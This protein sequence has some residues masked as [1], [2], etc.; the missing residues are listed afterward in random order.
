MPQ[1]RNAIIQT[2]IKHIA[3]DGVYFRIEH[4]AQSAGVTEA[5]L[6]HYFPEQQL[7][8]DCVY[9]AIKEEVADYVMPAVE[10][11][12][13]V[14]SMLEEGWNRYFDWGCEHESQITA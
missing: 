12:H 3:T 2:T 14:F 7:L 1:D 4:I 13:D 11:T 8:V 9:L 5:A 6:Y 10:E